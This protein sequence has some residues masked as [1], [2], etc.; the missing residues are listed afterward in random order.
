MEKALK[1]REK[2]N[3][4]FISDFHDKLKFIQRVYFNKIYSLYSKK[5]KI[6]EDYKRRIQNK[7]NDLKENISKLGDDICSL[8]LKKDS[9]LFIFLK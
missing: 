4:L 6:S 8:Q 2:S 9:K 7:N 5:K 1:D 3:Q